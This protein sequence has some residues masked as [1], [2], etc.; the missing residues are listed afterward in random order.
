MPPT[1]STAPMLAGKLTPYPTSPVAA[2]TS[3]PG[4]VNAAAVPGSAV[5]CRPKLSLIT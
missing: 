4:G 3:T 2:T 5:S 1:A